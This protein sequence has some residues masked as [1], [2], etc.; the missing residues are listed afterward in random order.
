MEIDLTIQVSL[1]QTVT[2][3]FILIHCCFFSQSGVSQISAWGKQ[4]AA[5]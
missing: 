5:G 3:P 4:S 2:I 1:L